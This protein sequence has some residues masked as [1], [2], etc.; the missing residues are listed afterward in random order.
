MAS[1]YWF[2]A[3]DGNTQ[4]YIY[5]APVAGAQPA[6]SVP[7]DDVFSVPPTGNLPA[8]APV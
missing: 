1:F 4:P 8:A 5:V 3:P 7:L 2:S 6:V